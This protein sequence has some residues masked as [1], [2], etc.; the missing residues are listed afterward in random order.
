V[1]PLPPSKKTRA[2]L[3]YICLNRRSFRREH[4]CELLWE[5]PDDPRGSLRWSLSKLRRLVDDEDKPRIVADRNNV[6][7]DVDDVLID[8]TELGNLCSRE[9]ADAS[10]ERLEAAAERFRGNFLEGLEFSNFHDFHS[11]CVAQRE[12]SLRDRATLLSAL[13]SRLEDSPERAL[14]HARALVGLSPYD[15]THR[16]T[17]IRLLNAANQTAEA[18]EQYE[19]GLRMLKEAGITPTGALLRARQRAAGKRPATTAAPKASPRAAPARP[20]GHALV[21]REDEVGVLL[22]AF[23]TVSADKRAAT[24]LLLGVPGIGKSRVL[25]S[26]IDYAKDAGAFVLNA[27]AFESDAIRPFAGAELTTEI[28]GL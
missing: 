3:A 28:E 27:T 2:L 19:L 25:Q 24:V 20:R 12:Q 10:I 11:W 14:P 13:V 18:D 17:L 7:A 15:E 22:D 16:A 23:E 21:G 8:V 26:L 9:L 6:S 4:L 5:V 1:L